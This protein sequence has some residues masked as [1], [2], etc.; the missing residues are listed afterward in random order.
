MHPT[1]PILIALLPKPAD[2]ERARAGVYRIPLASAPPALDKASAL[3]LYQPSSFGEGRWQV[4]WWGPVLGTE[5]LPRREIVPEEPT[6]RRANEL[7]LRVRLGP[8]APVEP[9]KHAEK[10]R[11][12]LF[13]PTS[14]GAFLAA[15]TLDEL[16][17]PAPRPIA[18]S[19]IFAS[20]W[21]ALEPNNF[22][23][24]RIA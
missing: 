8:L 13:I 10:G 2:L 17:I 6:H 1:D 23:L 18:D 22:C 20:I 9:P 3:A 7:Y 24:K 16:L 15:A 14:W 4:Q 5:T 21:T 11:R 19:P 12:I